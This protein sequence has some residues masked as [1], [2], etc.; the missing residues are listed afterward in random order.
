MLN[1][2]NCNQNG[3]SRKQLILQELTIPG[4]RAVCENCGAHVGIKEDGLILYFWIEI[5]FFAAIIIS[6]FYFKAWLG[7]LIFLVWSFLRM[8]I[9][10]N[11]KLEKY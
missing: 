2:P 6:A 9:K 5:V 1:C 3:I 7:V 8:V 4:V 11:G 10:S